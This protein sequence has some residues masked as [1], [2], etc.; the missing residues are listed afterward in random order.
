MLKVSS[1]GKNAMRSAGQARN[2]LFQ[3]LQHLTGRP[4]TD[5]SLIGAFPEITT[6]SA[7]SAQ[8]RD[9]LLF[10]SKNSDTADA[11]FTRSIL[12]LIL[13]NRNFSIGQMKEFLRKSL[14]VRKEQLKT[15]R[16][17]LF[18][19]SSNFKFAELINLNDGGDLIEVQ[20]ITDGILQLKKPQD[21]ARG[22]NSAMDAL[23]G[24]LKDCNEMAKIAEPAKPPDSDN[25]STGP[26]DI[27]RRRRDERDSDERFRNWRTVICAVRRMYLPGYRV[28]KGTPS[29]NYSTKNRA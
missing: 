10:S 16:Q 24:L 4:V 6:K 3:I 21:L 25:D 11:A 29:P 5:S 17:Y 19:S 27:P 9:L 7:Q 13:T 8:G 20:E 14:Q 2:E 15:P 26:H 23:R 22:L 12:G 28:L 18:G 1:D